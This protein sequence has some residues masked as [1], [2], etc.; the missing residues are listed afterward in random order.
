MS[1]FDGSIIRG[2]GKKVRI[3]F[4]YTT[5]VKLGR[6]GGSGV[7]GTI[8]RQSFR[9]Q[10]L[11]LMRVS[12]FL[13]LCVP[14]AG[15]AQSTMQSHS[16][17]VGSHANT[18]YPELFK[19]I[20]ILDSGTPTWAMLM[21]GQDPPVLTVDSLYQA[22]YA[23]HPFV[24]NIH[25]QNYKHWRR[26]VDQALD[27]QGYFRPLSRGEEDAAFQRWKDR[28]QASAAKAGGSGWI[29][30]GPHE[31]YKN[32]TLTPYSTQVNVYSLDQSAS[33]P[34]ILFCG[35][36]AGGVFR[37]ADKGLNWTLVSAP[38]EF[39]NSITV[40][41]IHPTL[42]DVVFISGNSRIYRTL[43][44]GATW[45][46][47]L[48]HGG[49]GHEVRFHPAGPD[50]LW[51][52][53]SK[54]FFRSV[55]AGSSWVQ[56]FS[57]ETWDV[58][59]HPANPDTVFLLK[60]S[61]TQ[62][63]AEVY[64]SADGG[65]IWTLLDNG[66]YQPADPAAAV[67]HGGK[68]AIPPGLPDRIY[69][70][71]IGDSKAGDNGWIGVY[72]SDDRGDTWTH[73][74]GQDG[75][76][77]Q[78]ANTM[79]WNVAAYSDG[80]H[81]GF[82]NFDLEASHQDPNTLWIGT[83]RLTESSDGAF[84]FQAIGAAESQRLSDVHADIQAIEVNGSDI[85][86]A[87]DGGINYSDD[88][89]LSHSSRKRGITGSDFWGFGAGWNEDVLVGGRYHNGNHGYYQTYG[90]LN[91]HV[92]GGVEESTGYVHPMEARR[93]LF[94]QWW[95]GGTAVRR[96][97]AELGGSFENLPS[98]PIL[99]NEAYTESNSSGIYFQTL[100]ADR[101]YAG[102]G[103]SLWHSTDGGNSFSVLHDFGA[104]GRTLEVAVGHL[105]P[106]TLYVVF[107]PNG[108]NVRQLYRSDD[109]GTTWLL[110][111]HV[112]ANN[113]NKLEIT[114]NPAHAGE[115][116]VCANDA[117][118]GQKVFRSTDAGQTWTNRTTAVLDGEHPVDIL[119]QGGTAGIVY[120]VTRQHVFYHDPATGDWTDYSTGLPLVIRPL[121]FKPFYRDSKL[122]LATRGRGIW[123]IPLVEVSTPLAQ[124]I[125]YADTLYCS[126]DTAYFDSH[127]IL[128]QAGADWQWSFD[129]APLYV[130]SDTVRNPQ[131][132]FGADGSYTVG[133]TV[134]DGSGQTH[135]RQ[136]TGMV[137]VDS[138]CG[139]EA[140]PGRAVRL[141]QAGDWVQTGDLNLSTNAFSLTAW[142]KPDG[143]QPD[144]SAVA[145]NDGSHVVGFNFR[146]GNNTLGYHYPGG[147]WWWDSGLEVP[148]GEWSH[149][150]MVAE[151]TGVTLYLNGIGR[152]HTFSAAPV[153]LTRLKL[154][155]YRGWNSRNMRGELEEVSMWSRALSQAEIRERMHL[156]LAAD[157]GD[158]DL[159][160]YYQFNEPAG[161]VLNRVGAPVHGTLSG[162]TA[163]RIGSD[164]PAGGGVSG[165]L[166]IPGAGVY[167]FPEADVRISFPAGGSYPDGELA[168]Y[169]LSLP[170][171]QL[172]A[173]GDSLAGR[174]YWVIRHFGTSTGF[175]APD[176]LAFE[177]LTPMGAVAPAR[178]LMYR[179]EANGFGPTWGTPADTAVSV[180]LTAPLE[181][182][183]LFTGGGSAGFGQYALMRPPVDCPGLAMSSPGTGA[184]LDNGCADPVDSTRWYFRWPS[185]PDA[186]AYE[187]EVSR[188]GMPAPLIR[189][190]SLS[191]TAFHY[192][193][194]AAFEPTTDWQVRVRSFVQ[195]LWT[196]FSSWRPFALEPSGTDCGQPCAGADLVLDDT[197]LVPNE[198][199]VS[200]GIQS[201]GS[202]YAGTAVTLRAG[203]EVSLLPGF[204]VRP[205][206]VLVVEMAGCD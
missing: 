137:T 114:I 167:T 173:G 95:S 50:T 158:P 154:G 107:K 184:V 76:P 136:V 59:H 61:T 162:N 45:S 112:P 199:R 127:S 133:L 150:A 26:Q 98:M 62:V 142:V 69:V 5:R 1:P 190:S 100:Y 138:R 44:G 123:E 35:T 147:A 9:H 80:Y 124:P 130:S 56:L 144:Y 139:V 182:A 12:L 193:V 157:A 16:A 120:L 164:V 66:W 87:S 149:V 74:A 183:V 40:T 156:T 30:L 71:L 10:N 47:V 174:C 53:T 110:L 187:L 102:E 115:I 121:Q 24:K 49:T 32:G 64:R 22:Y 194:P 52:A 17:A 92:A 109:G 181:G 13:L 153:D 197:P 31:T 116:W 33:H 75:G 82:Y 11:E 104:G 132:V 41:E 180:Q 186:T 140:I 43:D 185:C 171:D 68:I 48:Y 134:T 77:Y 113:R 14:L 178:L 126:R 2:S 166:G 57:E 83:I 192:T 15:F 90:P 29:C 86:V 99:P 204:E 151:P 165:R 101:V 125:T 65:L 70:G 168:A 63:R 128:D 111:P 23:E 27:A 201:Q 67:T 89:L 146:E 97:A 20:P 60:R 72:R 58:D 106:D 94:S 152:K 195:G 96:L 42:P 81:Q 108:T 191:D 200:G 196:P 172:P 117:A 135:T 39:S 118:N 38:A 19:A 21:Y 188:V 177:A 34:D 54:G 205:G 18:P 163:Q 155:N 143:I 88:G 36:E 78:S 51:C 84:S 7:S 4:F 206:G 93:A 141:A 160:L 105:H 46:E 79:P 189:E 129:P 198:Y 73:P 91:S 161:Q 170:P 28:R 148:P 8:S 145:M 131:V 55:D 179:R 103:S 37:T 85:W 25:T 203:V 202:I 176:S 169:R 159:R 6:G 119:F 3:L 122:R 175:T